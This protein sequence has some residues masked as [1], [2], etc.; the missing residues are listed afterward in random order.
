MLSAN[1]QLCLDSVAPFCTYISEYIVPTPRDVTVCKHLFLMANGLGEIAAKEGALKLK[2]LTYIH[3]QAVNLGGIAQGG[4]YSYL[5]QHARE[6]P[7]IFVLLDNPFAN[8]GTAVADDIK[9]V[10][11]IKEK[12]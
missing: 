10:K 11:L 9:S 6:T 1:V 12:I 3:C 5:Q 2:E 4:Q 8:S 7:V